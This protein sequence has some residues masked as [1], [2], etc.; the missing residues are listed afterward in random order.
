MLS[1]LLMLYSQLFK[2]VAQIACVLGAYLFSFLLMFK[3]CECCKKL[4][5]YTV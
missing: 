3:A 5:N 2:A 4:F 1:Y